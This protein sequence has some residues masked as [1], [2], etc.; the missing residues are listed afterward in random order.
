[1]SLPCNVRADLYPILNHRPL[2]KVYILVFPF[3]HYINYYLLFAQEEN[4]A[5]TYFIYTT[6]ERSDIIFRDF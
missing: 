3:I 2:S 6:A 4:S 1:M 5:R